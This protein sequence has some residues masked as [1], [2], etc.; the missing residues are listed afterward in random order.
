MKP[1]PFSERVRYCPGEKVGIL[2]VRP[3]AYSGLS[4]LLIS[5]TH[6]LADP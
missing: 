1:S 3:I 2:N 5:I 6:L 4:Y